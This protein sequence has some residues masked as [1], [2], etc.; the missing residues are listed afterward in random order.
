MRVVVPFRNRRA[1]G[2]IVETDVEPGKMAAKPVE[3]FPDERAGDERGI[4][5]ALPWIAEYYV[6]PL[7]VVIRSA[8]PA[9]LCVARGA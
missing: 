9:A 7:G 8:L 5:R 2:V 4:A 3:S 6:A 1:M